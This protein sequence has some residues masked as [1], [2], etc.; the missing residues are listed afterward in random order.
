MQ[1]QLLL[2]S[3]L[4]CAAQLFWFKLG[5]GSCA[6]LVAVVVRWVLLC[7]S[8]RAWQLHRGVPCVI[9]IAELSVI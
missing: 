4:C 7:G 1:L 8:M 6:A 3:C 2:G 5:I 9:I